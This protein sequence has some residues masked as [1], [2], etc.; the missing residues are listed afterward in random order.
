MNKARSV[1]A[2][3]QSAPK[4][5]GI[6]QAEIVRTKGSAVQWFPL[7]G[8]WI[9][10]TSSTL[11][12]WS[13]EGHD[14]SGALAWQA[15][16]VTGMAAP[17]LALLAGLAEDREKANR[18]GGTDIRP[19]SPYAIRA[20][21]I[22][23]LI[24]VSALFHLMNFGSSWALTILDGREGANSLLVA[25]GLAFMCSISTLC[26]FSLVARYFSIVMTLLAAVVYQ[27][28]GTLLSESALWN[29]LPPTWPVRL[30]LPVLGVHSNAVPLTEG[31]LL[32]QETPL[33][34]IV[35]NSLFALVTLSLTVFARGRQRKVTNKKN[36]PA[37]PRQSI[38]PAQFS[39]DSVY[40]SPDFSGRNSPDNLALALSSIRIA[41]FRSS[42]SWLLFAVLAVFGMMTIFYPASYISGFYTFFV[43][44]LGAGLLPILSWKLLSSAWRVTVLENAKTRV[45]YLLWHSILFVFLAMVLGVCHTFAGGNF[46]ETM[47]LVVLWSTTGVVLVTIS[48]VLCV[49]Y[50]AG[51]TIAWSIFITVLSATLGGDVLAESILWVVALPAWPEI[52]NTPERLI[53]AVITELLVLGLTVRWFFVALRKFE[54]SS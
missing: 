32:A 11:A 30:L 51:L 5:S 52:A 1:F 2:R 25:V 35:L 10:I 34:G 40:A 4:A 33:Q 28:T 18:Y 21:R 47:K 27:V 31:E 29:L 43:L 15:M 54:R 50:G 42:I 37:Q 17:L 23:V 48:T 36:T 41:L 16:Y 9:G 14:A 24:V 8:L 45:S 13:A 49:S 7:I 22:G 44:P 46:P 53:F 19:V 6:I 12:F 3:S 20:A 38:S 26:I 39:L